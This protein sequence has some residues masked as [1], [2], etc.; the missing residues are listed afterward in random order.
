MNLLLLHS[1]ITHNVLLDVGITT[2]IAAS[3][4]N[5]HAMLLIWPPKMLLGAYS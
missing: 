4:A 2:S 3:T 1:R 5:R